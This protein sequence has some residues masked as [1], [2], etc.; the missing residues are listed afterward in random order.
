[1]PKQN[2]NGKQTKFQPGNKLGNRFKPGETGNPNGRPKRTALTDSLRA[3]LQEEM[4]NADGKTIADA[5]ARKL[6]SLALGGD[7]QAISLVFDRTEGKAPISL[8]V[9]AHTA[10][11]REEVE[12]LG[13]DPHDVINE[14]KLLI[15]SAD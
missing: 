5:L 1:M 13:L 4:P 9:T 14:A 6:L 11:W 3:Q 8:D 2:T 15:E 10:D 12:R 7:L